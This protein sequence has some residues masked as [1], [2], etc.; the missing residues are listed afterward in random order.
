MRVLF[1]DLAGRGL[2][3]SLVTTESDRTTSSGTTW[4]S[5]IADTL[6]IRTG[7]SAAVVATAM[8]AAIEAAIKNRMKRRNFTAESPRCQGWDCGNLIAL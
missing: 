4:I 8:A 7:G 5:L 3:S 1:L 6:I 2:F